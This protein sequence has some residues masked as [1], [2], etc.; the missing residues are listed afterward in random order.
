MRQTGRY[1]FMR[2]LSRIWQ[3]SVDCRIDCRLDVEAMQVLWALWQLSLPTHLQSPPAGVECGASEL[4][5][6]N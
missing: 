6:Q 5:V 3:S 4:K 2:L 1:L